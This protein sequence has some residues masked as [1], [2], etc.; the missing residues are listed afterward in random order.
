MSEPEAINVPNEPIQS[1][2]PAQVMAL[3]DARRVKTLS[4]GML[5]FKRFIRNKLAVIGLIILV[6]MFLFSFVGPLL[7]PYSQTQVFY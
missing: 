5:V 2:Q 3:D 6:L 7:S 1:P 4:P